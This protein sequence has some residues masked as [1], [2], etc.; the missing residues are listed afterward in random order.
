MCDEITIEVNYSEVPC[1]LD[2]I[3]DN[4]TIVLSF[5]DPLL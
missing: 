2:E 3:G 4:I 1:A 5:Y